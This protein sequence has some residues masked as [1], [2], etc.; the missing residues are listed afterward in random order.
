MSKRIPNS[1]KLAT[2]LAAAWAA[3]FADT[4]NFEIECSSGQTA[5]GPCHQA[6]FQI[7]PNFN[8]GLKSEGF[9]TAGQNTPSGISG[10]FLFDNVTFSSAPEPTSIWL[11]GIGLVI[12][13]LVRRPQ[14]S[15]PAF[16][17][18]TARRR[19]RRQPEAG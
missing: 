9:A 7:A 6:D 16:R 11:F 14:K 8:S 19:S 10:D 5:S 12:L 17:W 1:L 3:A 18:R 15:V 13:G 2:L 4:I